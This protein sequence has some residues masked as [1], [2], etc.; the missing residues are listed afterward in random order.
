MRTTPRHARLALILATSLTAA[1]ALSGCSDFT[2][3]LNPTGTSVQ[4]VTVAPVTTQVVVGGTVQFTALVLPSG[5]PDKS[6]TW[7]VAPSG[8]ARIDPNGVLTAIAP[9]QAVITATSVATPV[10]TAEAAVT[11][12]AAQQ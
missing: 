8:L 6:V 5:V 9:G 4:S 1:C 3:I 10:H 2:K 12:V 7:S 11:I